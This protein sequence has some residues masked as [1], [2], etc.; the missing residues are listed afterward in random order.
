VLRGAGGPYC[1]LVDPHDDTS[2]FLAGERGSAVSIALL[3]KGP[4][5]WGGACPA[6]ARPGQRHDC[7]GPRALIT[8]CATGFRSRRRWPTPHCL[9]V[10]L[11]S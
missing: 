10:Q 8:C 3:H 1:W 6:V 11:C 7:L 9:L 4:R 2:A 5:P